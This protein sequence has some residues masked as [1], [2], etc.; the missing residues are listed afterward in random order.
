[1]SILCDFIYSSYYKKEMVQ[2]RSQ[3]A[4]PAKPVPVHKPKPKPKPKPKSTTDIMRDN[5]KSRDYR[6]KEN[7]HRLIKRIEKG[8]IPNGTTLKKYQVTLDEVNKIRE[9][10]GFEKIKVFIPNSVQITPMNIIQQEINAETKSNLAK[11]AKQE[12]IQVRENVDALTAEQERIKEQFKGRMVDVN[13]DEI[14]SIENIANWFLRNPGTIS[15]KISAIDE[16]SAQRSVQTIHRMF[17]VWTGGYV[18]KKNEDGIEVKIYRDKQPYKPGGQLFRLFNYWRPKECDGD[19]THCLKDIDDLF[20]FVKDKSDW[21][22]ATKQQYFE[23]LSIT[24]REYPAF[25]QMKEQPD[26]LKKIAQEIKQYST[27]VQTRRIGLRSKEEITGFDEIMRLIR[28][29]Y[30]EK[31]REEESKKDEFNPD[32]YTE[33]EFNPDDYTQISKEYLYISMYNEFPLRDNMNNLKIIREEL[34]A[35]NKQKVGELNN[36]DNVLFVPQDESERVTFAL[37]DYKTRRLFGIVYGDFTPTVSKMIRTY[38]DDM[39]VRQLQRLGGT[40]FGKSKMSREIGEILKEIGVKK[41][42][43]EPGYNGKDNIG[44]ITLLRKAYVTRELAKVETDEER[45]KLAFAMKHSPAASLTY[46]RKNIDKFESVKESL[47]AETY[48]ETE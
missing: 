26:L 29:K 24:V 11:I 40:L 41:K 5:R 25:R 2:T 22:D 13:E 18:V 21:K 39:T 6:F 15:D 45:D 17:N 34:T 8:D 9:E 4:T 28:N 35:E 1:M 30:Q 14:H 46:A 37:I 48:D 3:K 10:N 19:I 23:T 36:G 32:D 16:Q 12:S 33:I 7:Y 44:N 38:I 42:K 27:K 43:G 47:K 31:F 20:K